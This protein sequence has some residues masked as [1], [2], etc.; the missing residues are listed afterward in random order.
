MWTILWLA[1]AAFIGF[2]VNLYMSP[3]M[4]PLIG[5]SV[6]FGSGSVL[7]LAIATGD[8]EFI[9]AILEGMGELLGAIFSGN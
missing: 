8:G 6:G 9:G 4:N 1:V 2:E 3:D 5:A 7:R